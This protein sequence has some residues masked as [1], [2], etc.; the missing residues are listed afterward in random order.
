MVMLSKETCFGFYMSPGNFCNNKEFH[1]TDAEYD[2]TGRLS[3][4]TRVYCYIPLFR[5]LRGEIVRKTNIK[6]KFLLKS[7]D[8]D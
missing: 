5:S 6:I 7:G 4:I 1:K 8:S 3:R 2:K